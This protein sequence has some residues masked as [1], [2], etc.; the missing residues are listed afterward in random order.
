MIFRK[1]LP[2]C[3]AILFITACLGTAHAQVF[4]KP[5]AS[6]GIDSFRLEINYQNNAKAVFYLYRRHETQWFP[7]DSALAAKSHLSDAPTLD[8]AILQCM[9]SRQLDI[10]TVNMALLRPSRR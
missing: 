7:V 2:L 1:I 6:P 8:L 10:R 3:A 5:A 9:K 4:Q